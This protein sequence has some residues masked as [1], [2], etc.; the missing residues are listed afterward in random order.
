MKGHFFLE[1][2]SSTLIQ[3]VKS[4]L[5]ISHVNILSKFEAQVFE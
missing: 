5:V 4:I 1:G 2:E 3:D